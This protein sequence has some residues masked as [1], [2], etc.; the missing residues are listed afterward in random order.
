MNEAPLALRISEVELETLPEN[1]AKLVVPTVSV[2]MSVFS[3]AELKAFVVHWLK[4]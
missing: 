4:P 3:W 1:A 2:L